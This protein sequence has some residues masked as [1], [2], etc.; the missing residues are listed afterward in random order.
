MGNN[1][2]AYILMYMT[3]LVRLASHIGKSIQMRTVTA[4]GSW[5]KRLPNL[6]RLSQPHLPRR[7]RK[8]KPRKAFKPTGARFCS[9]VLLKLP[10]GDQLHRVRHDL[11]FP[12]RQIL[13]PSLGESKGLERR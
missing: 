6:Q 7:L 13:R 9:G 4:L 5:P 1:A 8:G 3:G 11:T 2:S 12:H 10:E